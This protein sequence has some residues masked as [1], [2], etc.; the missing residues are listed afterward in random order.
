[1][2]QEKNRARAIAKAAKKEW[3]RII[4]PAAEEVKAMTMTAIAAA[5]AVAAASAM[6][7]AGMMAAIGRL[8]AI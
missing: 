8:L 3:G 7:D 5:A 4:W 1:M 6:I 2:E